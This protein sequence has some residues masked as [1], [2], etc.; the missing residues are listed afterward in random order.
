MHTRDT[1][2]YMHCLSI[3]ETHIR[4]CLMKHPTERPTQYITVTWAAYQ[5]RLSDPYIIWLFAP[6]KSSKRGTTFHWLSWV[7][8]KDAYS[9]FLSWLSESPTS[10]GLY[11]H[12]SATSALSTPLIHTH[13]NTHTATYCNAHS[14]I[15]HHAHG[16]TQCNTARHT[17]RNKLQHNNMRFATHH[18]I[19]LQHAATHCNTLQ[20]TTTLCNTIPY[21]SPRIA[22]ATLPGVCSIF[23]AT[24]CNTL[25]HAATHCNT[26]QH[27]A[28]QCSTL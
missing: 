2:R 16:S 28:T 9:R 8:R 18:R 10:Y 20:R 13:C 3:Q 23:T 17:R 21:A 25:Q 14:N 12:R 26:L 5:I 24:R 6:K 1:C 22:A 11:R 27:S 19:T 4:D 15:L 7:L